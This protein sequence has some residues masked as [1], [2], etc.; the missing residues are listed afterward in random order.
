MAMIV[1]ADAVQAHAIARALAAVVTADGTEAISVADR[2]T[3]RSALVIVFGRPDDEVA[4][5]DPATVPP[6]SPTELAAALDDATL[7]L[8][9][10][11][12][13]SVAALVDVDPQRFEQLPRPGHSPADAL[14][15]TKLAQVLTYAG[16]LGVDA[17]FVRAVTALAARNVPA[18]VADMARNAAAELPDGTRAGVDAQLAA[19]YA[20]LTE[21]PD[22]SLGRAFVEHYRRND[23]ALPGEVGGPAE[24]WATPHDCV[25][26]LAGYPTSAQGELLV[27]A[28]TGG[29]VGDGVRDFFAG[30]VLPAVLAYHLGIGADGRARLSLDAAKVWTAWDRGASMSRNLFDVDDPWDFRAHA[31]TSIADLRR[32]Y[33]IAHLD[34][35]FAASADGDVDPTPFRR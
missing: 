8:D 32:D 29:M 22:G 18:A 31:S 16:A 21:L 14:D 23:Y 3:V 10:V 11:R 13:L 27:A 12:V 4:D 2:A 5:L 26:I 19:R 33:D 35:R 20:A 7:R 6:I 28:F 34:P 1:R 24:A 25:H 30:H 15:Q 17:D 9:C